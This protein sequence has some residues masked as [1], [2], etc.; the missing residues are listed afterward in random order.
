MNIVISNDDGYEA[1]GIRALAKALCAHNV[2]IVAPEGE[3]SGYSHMV[4]FF[5]GVA[6]REVKME[7]GIKTYAVDGSPADC[8]MFASKHLFKDEKIDLVLTGINNVLNIGSDIL[9]SGTFGAAQEGTFNRIPSIAVS[10]KESGD[11]DYSYAAE[12]VVKNLEK[13]ASYAKENVTVNVNFPSSDPSKIKGVRVARLAYHPY[14]ERYVLFKKDGRERYFIDGYPIKDY[15]YASDSDVKL[16][17]EGYITVTP[18]QMLAT[19]ESMNDINAAELK[20]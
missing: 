19:D 17:H 12:F 6:Y 5:Q 1:R 10:L 16:I 7:D 14:E 8:I 18:V 4:G 9:F 15:P 13:L 20:L 2:T 3:R 11:D